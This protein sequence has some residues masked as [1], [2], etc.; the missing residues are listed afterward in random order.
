MDILF[1]G[2]TDHFFTDTDY[3]KLCLFIEKCIGH[4]LCAM[5]LGN[6]MSLQPMGG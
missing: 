1:S 2:K 6:G 5:P 3:I 4:I